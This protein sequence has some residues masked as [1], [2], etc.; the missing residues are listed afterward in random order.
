MGEKSHRAIVS[1]LAGPI[2]IGGCSTNIR[3]LE[4]EKRQLQSV[5][6]AAAVT[7]QAAKNQTY[8]P[9]RYDLYLFLNASVFDQLLTP[10]DGT[11]VTLTDGRPIRLTLASARMKFRAGSPVVSVTASAVD[12]KTGI[13]ADVELDA[14]MIIEGDTTAPDAMRLRLVATRLVP[15]LKWGPLQFHKWLFVR[16][17]LQL[18]AGKLTEKIAPIPLPLHSN[19]EVGGPAGQQVISFP[20]GNGSS[21]T[22]T[23]NYPETRISGTIR[24]HNVL[25]L[26]NGVHVYAQVEG[27]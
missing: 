7:E 1:V 2:L 26:K 11:E 3:L 10:F 9:Q 20:T 22:G 27:L 4:L 15:K 24:V 18:E 23:I 13:S 12:V 5:A 17:L 8:D 14:R 25:F 19:F 21:V 16:R 6:Q